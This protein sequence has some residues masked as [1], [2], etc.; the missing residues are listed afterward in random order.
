LESEPLLQAVSAESAKKL[1]NSRAE[2]R[3]VV[4]FF[5]LTC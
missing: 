3:S 4:I 5:I 2:K 1:L